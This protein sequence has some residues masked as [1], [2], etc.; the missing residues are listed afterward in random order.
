MLDLAA[1]RGLQVLVLTCTPAGY[2]GLGAKEIRLTP[3]PWHELT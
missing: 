1:T 2:I 3:H